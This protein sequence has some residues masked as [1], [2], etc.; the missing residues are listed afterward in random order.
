MDTLHEHL[1][2]F[3]TKLTKYLSEWNLFQ[4]KIVHLYINLQRCNSHP[5]FF[6]SVGLGR[7]CYLL[8]G[9]FMKSH[10]LLISNDCSNLYNRLK[11]CSNFYFN[12]YEIKKCMHSITVLVCS[13]WFVLI[14]L[15]T[16]LQK[17]C[18][19]CLIFLYN[20]CLKYSS[21]PLNM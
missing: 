7:A 18:I 4:T 14:I 8:R 6:K 17:S 1:A 3:C 11:A 2:H 15:K 9:Y 16:L 20:I 13:V 5:Q 10:N 12:H 21:F 19:V